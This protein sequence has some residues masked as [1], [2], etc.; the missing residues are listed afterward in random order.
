[1]KASRVVGDLTLTFVTDGAAMRA[2][3]QTGDRIIKVGPCFVALV[4]RVSKLLITQVSLLAGTI[5]TGPCVT[6]SFPT[7]AQCATMSKISLPLFLTSRL[8]EPW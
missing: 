1:M 7:S 6:N 4:P 5:W 3:V 8:M 2:G